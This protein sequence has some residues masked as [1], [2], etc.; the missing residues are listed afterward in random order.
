MFGGDE[1]SSFLSG[2]VLSAETGRPL[3]GVLVV[4]LSTD[5]AISPE[6]EPQQLT[7]GAGR[8]QVPT[9]PG[10][11]Y[12]ASVREGY[13]PVFRLVSEQQQCICRQVCQIGSSCLMSG[14]STHD[15]RI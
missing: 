8:F 9:V 1:R 14:V 11:H 6:P 4:V 12:V 2:L 13:S 7:G 5:G 3:E 15:P 10:T